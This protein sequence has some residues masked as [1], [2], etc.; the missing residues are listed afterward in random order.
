MF[1]SLIVVGFLHGFVLLPLFLSMVGI[2][3]DI[4]NK[5]KKELE[6]N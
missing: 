5:N 4:G 2:E 6:D 3:I 1:I